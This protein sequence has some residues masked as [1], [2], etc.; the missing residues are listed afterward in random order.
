MSNINSAYFIYILPKI[1]G[2]GGGGGGGQGPLCPLLP[3][4]PMIRCAQ[5]ARLIFSNRSVGSPD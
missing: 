2:G 1:G 5:V 4:V 3:S